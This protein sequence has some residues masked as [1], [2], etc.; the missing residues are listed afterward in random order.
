MGKKEIEGG[1]CKGS[2]LERDEKVGIRG[3]Q[4][5]ILAAWPLEVAYRLLV[6]LSAG[7]RAVPGALGE[8]R[9]SRS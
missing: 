4:E 5:A 2:L 9:K 6:K 1:Q 3:G 7:A 8:F